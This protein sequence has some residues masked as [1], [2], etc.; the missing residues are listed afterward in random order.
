[1][2]SVGKIRKQMMGSGNW[3]LICGF[4]GCLSWH[5]IFCYKLFLSSLRFAVLVLL[6]LLFSLLTDLIRGFVA[7]AYFILQSLGSVSGFTSVRPGKEPSCSTWPYRK[8]I[9]IL[10]IL[11]YR[12]GL[13]AWEESNIWDRGWAFGKKNSKEVATSN[14]LIIHFKLCLGPSI[15][16][17][18]FRNET[19]LCFYPPDAE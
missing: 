6:L 19:A 2:T 7:V 17:V 9:F 4:W 10:A 12:K 16:H 8:F 1:M 5:A 3:F 11:D 15:Y 14:I 13:G 18:C